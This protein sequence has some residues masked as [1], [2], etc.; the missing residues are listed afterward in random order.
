M[1]NKLITLFVIFLVALSAVSIN[2][3]KVDASISV[4]YVEV[5]PNV[6]NEIANYKIVFNITQN[7]PFLG[8]IT[9]IFPPGTG[10]PCSSCNPYIPAS[11][12][13]VNGVGCTQ[14]GIGNTTVREVDIYSPI[15]LTAGTQV[16]VFIS[17]TARISNP[18][19]EG[20]YTLQVSTQSEPDLVTSQPFK[21]GKSQLSVPTVSL[22]DNIALHNSVYAINFNAGPVYTLS[23]DSD[24]ITVAFPQGTSIPPLIKTG[25]VT[26]NNVP[27]SRDLVTEV[28]NSVSVPLPVD[29]SPGANINLQ[30]TLI[31]GIKNPS[32]SG[33]KTL[34]ISSSKDP[35]RIESLPYEIVDISNSGTQIIIT[36][37][38]PNGKNDWYTSLPIV[39]FIPRLPFD[40]SA[41][42]YYKID[43]GDFIA[44][45]TPFTVPDGVHTIYYY[46]V[47]VS[48][49][50]TEP[51]QSKE[52]KVDTAPPKLEITEPQDNAKTANNEC[53]IKGT[54][55]DISTT[56]LLINGKEI[57]VI[58]S[59]FETIVNLK[60]GA[61][62]IVLTCIDEAG[63]Q[64]SINLHVIV[65]SVIPKIV[66]SSPKNMSEVREDY[67][68]V[69]GTVDVPSVVAVNSESVPVNN[70]GS[71]VYTILLNN[72]PQGF[73]LINVVATSTESGLSATKSIIVV[74]NPK[75][76]E[77]IMKLAIDSTQAFIDE[78]ITNLDSPPYVD[79]S[80]NRTLVPL[81]FIAEAFGA[82]V[83]WD[84]FT[85]TATV[86][87]NEKEIKIQ[88]G[89][90]SASVNGNFVSLDQP[91][92][93]QNNRTMVPIRFIA[94]NLGAK[95]DWDPAT[96]TITI[97][98]VP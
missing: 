30:F 61:N 57:N 32:K 68:N 17:R 14:N 6:V 42:V 92:V 12:I 71:F 20:T 37:S 75:P 46:T 89:N 96:K 27:V 87:L 70:D 44:F 7:V 22:S 54:I 29:V 39:G 63:N 19:S 53:T 52:I 21:I 83:S 81:R 88:I 18:P 9:I 64:T 86:K 47:N 15:A 50:E 56:K 31:A 74:Y 41:V 43:Q 4:L 8:K 10:I 85:R 3:T 62:S 59:S 36:P 5:T 49:G 77:I 28:D 25:S 38:S 97:T 95:V 65:S 45:S 1:K 84:N 90:N 23:Q 48:Y 72:V 80:T 69:Q 93:I 2:L 73:F 78:N 60:E 76:K 35:K 11:A 26:V 33:Q 58:D 98:Y 55:S 79:Q 91:P 82:E 40:S 66:I 24:F 34:F 94:E 13:S 67:I 16:T 51:V